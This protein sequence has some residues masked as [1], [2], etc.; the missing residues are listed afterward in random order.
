MLEL[1]P[2][3]A[4]QCSAVL[5]AARIAALLAACSPA[6]APSPAVRS[7]AA[8]TGVPVDGYPS[9]QERL[10]LAAINRTRSD[11]NNVALG[12]ATACSARYSAQKPLMLNT[13][14]S[15][16]ARFH[17]LHTL[18]NNAGL[19][20]NSYCTLKSDVGT[21]GCDGVASCAC[22]PGSE[23]FSCRTL[24]G[25]GTNP[26][27]R[28]GYFGFSANG[29]VGAAGNSDGWDANRAWVGECAGADGHRSILTGSDK[30]Q[31]GLGYA[32]GQSACWRSYYFGDTGFG[33][34]NT[35][36]LPSGVHRPEHGSGAVDFY[37]SY[38]HA[39]GAVRVD[40]VIDGRCQPMSIEL[41]APT[42][43][44]YQ[45]SVTVGAGC[46]EYWFL[47]K[48][49]DGNRRT[50][51]ESGA[52]GAGACSDYKADRLNAD[53]EDAPPPAD[54]GPR[55]TADSGVTSRADA[56][57][58]PNEDGSSMESRDAGTRSADASSMGPGPST[59][60]GANGTLR[61]DIGSSCTCTAAERPT[62]ARGILLSAG[63]ILLGWVVSR[64]RPVAAIGAAGR[65]S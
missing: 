40:V 16:A 19:S 11:P 43:A 33:R 5:L 1:R 50:Y 45:T 29:E 6:E 41:G 23:C 15:R 21:S 48:D 57:Q 14:G 24:G 60:A 49:G 28:A 63:L 36:V 52:Y 37:A 13:S 26:F 46:H 38:Y 44:T 51:P 47:A 53:C 10:M 35:A 42:N 58:S 27:A 39:R 17:A 20:H 22:V 9:Y 54:A 18:L 34:V 7:T 65:A 4:A 61:R 32:A 12:T 64:M 30:D 25:C 56:A 62:G 2:I 8:L 31:I 3:S 55:P 59:D